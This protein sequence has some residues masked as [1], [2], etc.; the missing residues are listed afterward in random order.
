MG[1]FSKKKKI[2]VS[3]SLWNLAGDINKRTQFLP[4]TIAIKVMSGTEESMSS[5][6]THSLLN[7]NG[8][9]FR[10]YARWARTA[11][12]D[13]FLGLNSST[14]YVGDNID[15]TVLAAKHPVASNQAVIIQ[16]AEVGVADYGFWVD[17]WMLENHPDEVT[18]SYEI[19]FDE[20]ANVVTITFETGKVYTFSPVG[21]DS[22][23]VYLYYSFV[24]TTTN[25]EGPIVEGAEII[26]DSKDDW[27][28][29][30]GWKLVSNTVTP[31][32]VTLTDTRHRKAVFS[33]GRPDEEETLTQDREFTGNE[34][35]ITHTRDFYQ[36]ASLDGSSTSTITRWLMRYT[37]GKVVN[38]EPTVTTTTETIPGENPGDPDVTVTITTTVTR[39]I[40]EPVYSY[41][42]DEMTTIN[43]AT[44]PMTVV[45]YQRGSNLDPEL[46]AM[47]SV[48]LNVGT[49]LP[50][51]P[52]RIWNSTIKSG[53]PGSTYDWNK[54]AIKKSM[55]KKYDF[56]VKQLESTGSIGDIDF[57]YCVFGVSLNTKENAGRKYIML[58]FQYLNTIGGGAAGKDDAWIQWEKDWLAAD[59]IQQDWLKW[60]TAQSNPLSPLYDTPE[61]PRATYPAQPYR[62]L[63]MRAN[64]LNFNMA[65]SYGGIRVQRIT[66]RYSDLKNGKTRFVLGSPS[67]TQEYQELLSSAGLSDTRALNRDTLLMYWQDEEDSFLSM[68]V[69][70]IWHNYIIYKGKGVDIHTKD[71]MTDPEESGCLIPLHEEIFR[72]MSLPDATQLATSCAYMVCNSYKV[73]K[74]KWYQSSWF[75]IVLIVAAIVIT[76]VS[77]GTGA[78]VGA[79]LLGT[80]AAVGASIGLAGTAA[81]IA[82]AAINA[83]A[84]FIVARIITAASV[85]LFGPEIGAIIGAIASVAVVSAGT[86]VMTGGT[87]LQG[88]QNIASAPNLLKMVA[89]VGQGFSAALNQKT[90]EL[91]KDMQQ[92]QQAYTSKMT[93]IYDAW[94][95]N[96][97]AEN[98]K[99]DV[100]QLTQAARER[101]YY[102]NL[103]DFLT[104]TLLTGSDIANTTNGL[105]GS[106]VGASTTTQLP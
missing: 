74:K 54:K 50:F 2:Y 46:E 89:S 45:I 57:A 69:S 73:V 3:S 26:V 83:I 58:F 91:E 14:I 25:E 80:A 72:K 37:R 39:Q 68:T 82:G 16:T 94:T 70:G 62:T 11:G 1:L 92:L 102:E 41:R 61:P 60:H 99:I 29:I 7:G 9:K 24:T 48:P 65:L 95:Q 77:L 36:G 105:I 103:N 15:T 38:D 47:F 49:F 52:V 33:D 88:L 19:D 31:K 71:A 23:G 30:S 97:G 104:R 79:G 18:A 20:L 59:R 4:T 87:A 76:V 17:K 63:R 81:I 6:I 22:E 32:T 85:A 5:A 100:T 75:K 64:N 35:T 42:E 101:Y 53:G 43:S 55:G 56:L 90:A 96:L 44:S 86:S 21:F 40:V 12:Y 98:G 78:P 84:G 93:E 27:P 34:Q 51:V 67:S 28:S 106:F 66:G 8:I 10:S 13:R